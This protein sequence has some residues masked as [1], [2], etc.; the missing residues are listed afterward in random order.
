MSHA[1]GLRCRHAS[2][3]FRSASISSS[4]GFS[5]DE[6][7]FRCGDE[8]RRKLRWPVGHDGVA[9]EVEIQQSAI[10]GVAQEVM[11]FVEDDPMWRARSPPHDVQRRQYRTDVLELRLVFQGREIDDDA[12]VRIVAAREG[13]RAEEAE[14]LHRRAP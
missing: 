13:A 10:D 9:V 2:Q 8:L 4:I 5:R 12:A 11:A 1:D 3:W 7:D 14:A 6:D